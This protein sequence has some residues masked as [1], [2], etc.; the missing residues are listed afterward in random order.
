MKDTFANEVRSIQV[1]R[2]N[3]P[4]YDSTKTMDE[5]WNLVIKGNHYPELRTVVKPALSLFTAPHV[6]Q[7]FRETNDLIYAEKNRTGIG[8]LNASITVSYYLK[9]QRN[10]DKG[11]FQSVSLNLMYREDYSSD[12]VDSLICAEMSRSSQ[13]LLQASRRGSKNKGK[14]LSS[15]EKKNPSTASAKKRKK[16]S[17]LLPS[18]AITLGTKKQRQEKSVSGEESRKKAHSLKENSHSS[19]GKSHSSKEKTKSSKGKSHTSRDNKEKEKS[20][21]SRDNKNKEK[22]HTSRYNNNKEK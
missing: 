21:T 18:Y 3:L 5:W 14:P 15:C 20:H 10:M 4:P 13:V 2:D 9:K 8:L 16:V 7:C 12:P 6:E 17:Q 19:K 1:Y 22:S 11:R